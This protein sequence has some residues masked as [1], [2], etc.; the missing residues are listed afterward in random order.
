MNQRNIKMVLAFDGTDFSG[1]QTQK[2][3]RT[4]QG[5]IEAALEKIHNRK[6][7]ITG[8]G[9]TD[10]G[11]HANGQV[12]SF[13]TD[14]ST[15]SA[16]KF[17]LALNSNLPDDIRIITSCEIH[18]GFNAR[19]DAVLRSYKY[20]LSPI[21]ILNPVYRNYCHS[22]SFF[23]DISI[24]NNLARI[25]I[26]EHDFTTF[27]ASGDASKTKVRRVVTSCFYVSGSFL[28]FEIAANAFLWKMVRSIVGT[29]LD[30]ARSRS[31]KAG[32]RELKAALKA[33]DRSLAGSTAPA[34]GLFLDR[35]SYAKI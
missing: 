35:V 9:R 5:T 14:N 8:S 20:F 3:S 32:A 24:L 27:T 28:V 21:S 17:A 26:G 16:G 25:F 2:N 13:K 7:R 29:I 33:Q 23:P 34:K 6:I 31:E 1:W 15:I 30:Y 11:V 10:S 19:F 12:L 22:I 18:D 4:V